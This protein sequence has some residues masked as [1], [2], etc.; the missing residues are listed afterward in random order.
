MI[1]T[2]E[3]AY[4]LVSVLLG[5][6]VGYLVKNIIKI[7]LTILAIIIILI[8]I[9][10]ISP[11]TVISGIETVT[12]YTPQI[13]EYVSQILTY[14]PYNSLLFIIGFVIGLWKG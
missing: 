7:G 3:I 9:G 11:H 8:A 2:S 4:A 1:P 13:E 6:L 10:V 14:L 5:L 12:S